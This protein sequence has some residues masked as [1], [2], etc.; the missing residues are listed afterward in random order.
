M[1]NF[2]KA[3]EIGEF[4]LASTDDDG[5]PLFYLVGGSGSPLGIASA[6]PTLYIRDD[7]TLWRNTGAGINDW[8]E[9]G[10]VAGDSNIDGGFSLSTYLPDQCF[11]GGGA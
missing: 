10:G 6:I 8:I 4:G 3:Q 1:I 11:D 2:D 7:N 5:A 9:V